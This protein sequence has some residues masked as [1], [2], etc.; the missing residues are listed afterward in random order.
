MLFFHQLKYVYRSLL[1]QKSYSLIN[2]LGLAVA[3]TSIVVITLWVKYELSYD[4]FFPNA[5]RIYRFTEERNTPDGY[6]SHFARVASNY[7]IEDQFPEIEAKLRLA[8]LRYATMAV[9]DQKFKSDKVYFTDSEVFKVFSLKM[10]EGDAATA[11]KHSKSIIISEKIA[12]AYFSNKSCLGSTMKIFA[13]H[14]SKPETYTVTGVFEDLPANSHIH[15]E[16]L[17]SDGGFDKYNGWAYNYV[18]LAKNTDIE[19][20]RGKLSQSVESF[21]GEQYA[22]YFKFHLQSIKD[23]H[24]HSKKE[25]ELEQNGSYQSVVLL[26]ASALFIF[27]I[28][29]INAVNLNIALL[30]K[31][32]KYLKISK[33]SGAKSRDVL[34]LQIVKSVLT[35]MGAAMVSL[36][37][38]LLI[39][40]FLDTVFWMNSSFLK[41]QENE[42]FSIL[43][44]LL[45]MIVMLISFPVF[46]IINGRIRGNRVLFKNSG[47][48]GLFNPSARLIFRK[49]LL[50][51]QFTVSFVLI[52]CSIIIYLQMNLISSNKLQ[53]EKGE[54]VVFNKVSTPVRN[55]YEAFKQELL[56]NPSI[57]GVTASM[58]TPP[59]QIMDGSGFEIS[60]QTEDQKDKTIYINPVDDNYFDFYDQKIL[61]G[62]DFPPFVE[63]QGFDN[64][65][66]NET[67]MRYLGY[68]NPEDVVGKRFKLVH[69]MLDFK[70]GTILGLVQD[71]HYASLHHE[72]EPMVY[73]QRPMFYF[74]FYVKVD[75]MNLTQSLAEIQEVW[76][77]VYPNYP[78]DYVIS[79]QMYQQSYIN[80]YT[81]SKLSTGFSL[82][83]ILISF[84]GLIG[85][86]SIIA[87]RR[88]KEIGIRKVLGA[89]T[90]KI[91]SKLSS[92]F[93]SLLFIASLLAM[94]ASYFLMEK[95]LRNFV[96]RI[97][98][99]QNWWVFLIIFLSISCFVMFVV[100]LKAFMSS[101]IN[102]V[103]CIRDE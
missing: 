89:S 25:R 62:Q 78:F 96:Y 48:K 32:L 67:A 87:N 24:L 94:L 37:L 84:T 97:D 54:V 81:Q 101:R 3:M 45:V 31:E 57:K 41:N 58:E 82:V 65:I 7:R 10:L 68:N 8:P 33:I 83:A 100:T 103:D 73:F 17:V 30:F 85:L 44:I 51:I 16:L 80:E 21:K 12:L 92:E 42:I 19:Q 72:I 6:Q 75:S 38:I 28:A 74:S 76:E 55:K 91:V 70:E 71:F 46:F 35:C 95:W 88:K 60:G 29:L 56:Q 9:G 77:E 93:F 20:L 14:S 2:I 53:P 49:L 36:I 66:I 18:L 1:N 102:P 98:L 5:D 13:N 64:Y 22:K 26:G 99:V 11:L 40:D 86:S 4:Q 34:N 39:R 50:I 79:D 61:F 52:V 59:S 43:F 15:F 47:L 90:Y 27:L 23:I 63:G 69:S